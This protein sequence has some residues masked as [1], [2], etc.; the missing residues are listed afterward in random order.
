M[1]RQI[2]PP[3][4]QRLL[5]FANKESLAADPGERRRGELVT[6]RADRDHLDRESPDERLQPAADESGLRQ[7]E[8]ARARTNAQPCR[9][10]ISPRPLQNSSSWSSAPTVGLPES[11]SGS[12]S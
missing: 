11:P 6:A 2:Y 1:D 7:R 9:H 5:D 10:R 8:R 12:S 3:R 4:A